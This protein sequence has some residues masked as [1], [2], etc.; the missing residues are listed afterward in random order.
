MHRVIA[1]IAVQAVRNPRSVR[2]RKDQVRVIAAVQR[3]G[4]QTTI[5]RV[6]TVATADLVVAGFTPQLVIL[7]PAVDD[8]STVATI[9]PVR[10]AKATQSLPLTP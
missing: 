4:A 10:T 8:I 2:A 6:E 7:C 5:D 3:V 9:D 1:G